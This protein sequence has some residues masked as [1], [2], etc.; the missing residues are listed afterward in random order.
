M[1]DIEKRLFENIENVDEKVSRAAKESGRERKDIILCAAC[2]TMPSDIVKAAAKTGK[3]D[4]FGENRVQELCEHYDSG[5]FGGV[6]AQFIGH[7]QTN[8]ISKVLGRVELIQSVDSLH[9]AMAV[10]EKA[11]NSGKEMDVLLE[12]NIDS[13]E[14]KFGFDV[15]TIRKDI[16]QISKIK[17]INVRGIMAIPQKITEADKY[18]NSFE[19]LSQLFIDIKAEKYDNIRMDYLSMGMSGDFEKAIL[20]GANLVRVGT[21]I[22]GTRKI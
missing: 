17:G 16:E 9:L 6:P 14:S 13:E 5:A 20:C 19:R 7:L 15:K 3:I 22:F 4:V 1:T 10:A 11:V 18:S 21:A 2:K 12:I 8:K